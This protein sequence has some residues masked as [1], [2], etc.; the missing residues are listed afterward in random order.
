MAIVR[1][2]SDKLPDHGSPQDR[3]SADRYYMRP[4]D[5]HWWPEGTGHGERVEMAQ[6]DSD[7]IVEYTY[8]FNN[9]EDRKDWG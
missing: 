7:Q 4:Y 2:D 3:G 5:P 6:M 9:E 8:G 1:I